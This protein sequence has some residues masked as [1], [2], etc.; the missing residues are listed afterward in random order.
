MQGRTNYF[1]SSSYTQI[2]LI[3]PIYIQHY[4]FIYSFPQG[5]RISP[6]LSSLLL[7]ISRFRTHHHSRPFGIRPIT[8]TK[9]LWLGILLCQTSRHWQSFYNLSNSMC[10]KNGF[11]LQ[12]AAALR[13]CIVW[14]FPGR[15]EFCFQMCP[16][17]T[18]LRVVAARICPADDR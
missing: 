11:W 9:R 18:Q 10:L 5:S 3:L 17:C 2:F 1:Q 7:K 12:I 16:V 15:K 13:I 6:L 4:L 14:F 8:H